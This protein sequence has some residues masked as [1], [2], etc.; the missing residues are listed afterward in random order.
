AFT[1]EAEGLRWLAEPSALP[2]ARVL[3]VADEPP[4]PRFL[5]LEWIERGSANADADEQ[6]GRGLAALHAAGAP[7]FGGRSDL[8]L[9]PL[10]LPNAP[11]H[12][13]AEFYA[14]QRLEP[15]ARIAA[16]RGALPAGASQL[17]D[18]LVARLD[19]LCGPAE[20]PAR[21]HGDLWSGNVMTAA[22][23]QPWLIDPAAYGGHREVDL[24]MLRLFGAPG[25]RFMAAYEEVAPLADGHEQR[26]GLWQVMPL[27][28]HAAL[29][30][31]S[32][33]A[34]AVA[35]IGRYVA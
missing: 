11:L 34:S 31:G 13:W 25:P 33:G 29:F 1:R 6:L 18:R 14:T 19:D 5:A 28:A 15:L 21:L 10:T 4:G 22:G 35:A 16:D 30:G 23:G 3:A 12:G 7:S 24:A 20:P 32:W 9:G 8:V 27:L 17:V 26:V 2:V